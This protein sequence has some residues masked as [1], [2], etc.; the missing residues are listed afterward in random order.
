MR[1]CEKCRERAA[2]NC[3]HLFP[4]TRVNR[5]LYGKLI[6]APCNIQHLCLRCHMGHNGKVEH[7][8][9]AEFCAVLGIETRS[10]SGKL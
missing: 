2:E 7:I 9:E 4:Q 10:K 1:L 6:D 8:S 5:R 3:H